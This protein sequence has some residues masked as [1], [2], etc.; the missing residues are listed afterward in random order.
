MTEELALREQT[1]KGL[2]KRPEGVFGIITGVGLIGG[3]LFVLYKALPFLITLA[4]NLI[5]LIVEIV[6]LFL[7]LYVILNKDTWRNLSLIWYQLN[8]KLL[9]LIVDMDPISI[10]KKAIA[11]MRENLQTVHEKVTELASVIVNM[12][13]K[14][15]EYKAEFNDNTE[16]KKKL[17]EQIQSGRLNQKEL[18]AKKTYLANVNNA[19]VRGD[20][21]IRKQHERLKTSKKYQEIMEKLEVYA[22]YKVQDAE[23]ELRFKEEEF[24]QAKATRSAMKSIM[25]IIKGG[26]SE[27]MEQEMALASINETVNMSVAE[28]RRLI[29]GSNDILTSFEMNTDINA[30]KAEELLRQYD[31]NGFEIFNE[32]K[33]SPE[34]AADMRRALHGRERQPIL[35]ED[36]DY[37]ESAPKANKYFQ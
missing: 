37:T 18:Y 6:V 34:V 24:E 2:W 32:D 8:R 21:Q 20:A 22:N 4:S 35:V 14:L 16:I 3:L 17:E 25:G 12:E 30:D 1:L 13:K 19:I 11:E 23:N 15:K 10:L 36:V 31:A 33:E 27:T 29:E 7:L 9:G 5:W 26:L 28:M